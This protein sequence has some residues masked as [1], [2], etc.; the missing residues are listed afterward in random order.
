MGLRIANRRFAP[1]VLGVILTLIGVSV[2]V[3]LGVWQLHRA[4]EKRAL[5]AQFEAGERTTVELTSENATTQPRYQHVHAR[6]HYESA[7]QILLDNM[8]SASGRAGFRVVTPF[9]LDAGGTVLV[10]RGW[11]PLGANRRALPNVEVG[12][13]SRAVAGRFADLPRPGIT[14]AEPSI[15]DAAPW[16]RV[17]NF[18][19]HATLEHALGQTL[20]A[21]LVLLDPDQP[22]GYER[23]WQ[24]THESFSPERHVAYAVQWFGLAVAAVVIFVL[25]SLRKEPSNERA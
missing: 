17:M 1:S 3:R 11:I 16:P 21:G 24:L 10:D 2:F 20:V 9:V 23:A 6:G 18:P 13:S 8:P 19:Q 12:E 14:L 5:I 15:D 7:R 25:L 4:D 22:D